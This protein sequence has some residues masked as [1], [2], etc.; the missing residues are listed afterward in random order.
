MFSFGLSARKNSSLYAA[1]GFFAA[2]VWGACLSQTVSAQNKGGNSS[3][4]PA[5]AP[6]F[7]IE[8]EM[9]TYRALQSNSEAIG[10]G[11]AAYLDGVPA[12][13]TSSSS[14][15][16]CS[17]T[18]EGTGKPGVIVLP[19][20]TGLVDSFQLWRADVEIMHQLRHRAAP[21][22][23][24]TSQIQVGSRGVLGDIASATPAGGALGVAQGVFGMLATQAETS[25]VGGTIQ[26]Q[27]FM[28]A[29]ARQLRNL[30]VSVLM[31]TAYRP[32]S[33]NGLD[34]A[35]SPFLASF[36]AFLTTHDCVIAAAKKNPA[37]ATLQ[38][39]G[40]E[41][42]AFLTTLNGTT[43]S[44][45]SSGGPSPGTGG[46]APPAAD[47]EAAQI[48]SSSP[49]LAILA[50]DGLAQKLGVDPAS[51]Q[52]PDHGDWPHILF[53]KALESGGTVSAKRFREG[54]RDYT[55]DPASQLAAMRGSCKAP[56]KP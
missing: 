34:E 55:P 20:D 16:I 10:C 36:G 37:D 56:V 51:G 44:P 45:K 9:L 14:G 18:R 7:S 25:P 54:L 32:Y 6:G 52:L 50:A 13:F 19:F 24:T 49:L 43:P 31:P 30:D 46:S 3:S 8:S 48:S 53:L 15:S 23:S 28:N 11:I 41:M 1:C 4:A 2:F 29:V 26:D 12:T 47:G 21:Y 40:A 33:L 42:N 39:I 27:A 35:K 17:V 5:G 22:C 38:G